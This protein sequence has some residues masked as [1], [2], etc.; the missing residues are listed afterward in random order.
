[1]LVSAISLG[2]LAAAFVQLG[3]LKGEKQHLLAQHLDTQRGLLPKLSP[4]GASRI[5]TAV[6]DE[7][8][9]LFG[10][11]Y[12]GVDRMVRAPRRLRS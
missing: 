1:L 7:R 11:N 8:E 9:G 6:I 4:A 5:Q 3:A 12:A 10:D 2:I